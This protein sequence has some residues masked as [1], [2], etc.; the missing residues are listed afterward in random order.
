VTTLLIDRGDGPAVLG[1]GPM[2]PVDAAERVEARAVLAR[3][4]L[5]DGLPATTRNALSPSPAPL[6][7]VRGARPVVVASPADGLRAASDAVFDKGWTARLAFLELRET[8]ETA[9]ERFLERS[10]TLYQGEALSSDSRTKG[11]A[12]FAMA[13]LGLPEGVDEG[14]SLGRFLSRARDLLRRRE[15]SVGLFRTGGDLRGAPRLRE[16]HGF[17]PGAVVG[18]STDPDRKVSSERAR[19]VR[20]RAGITDVGCL[21]VALYP[22]PEST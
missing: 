13:T 17:P 12:T 4:G 14:P 10:E 20:M 22:R 19:A 21:A 9:A 3:T 1:G 18:A 6:P 11:I 2:R 5:A 15:M 7:R 16:E 8:A